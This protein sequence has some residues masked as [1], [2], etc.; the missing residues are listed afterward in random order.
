MEHFNFQRFTVLVKNI[1]EITELFIK[2]DIGL[3][4]FGMCLTILPFYQFNKNYSGFSLSKDT[5]MQRTF[6]EN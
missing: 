2:Y 6:L 3:K 4:I 5:I 1:L